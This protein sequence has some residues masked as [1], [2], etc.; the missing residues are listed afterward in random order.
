V[1]HVLIDTQA[2]IWFA[3]GSQALSKKARLAIDDS[4]ILQFASAASFW[5][6]AIKIPLGKLSLEAGTLREFT[7]LLTAN[8]IEVLGVTTDD[9][10]GVADLPIFDDHKDPFDRLIA[11]QCLRHNLT[12]V[13]KDASFDRYGVKPIW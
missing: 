6:M 3:N 11:A 10:V 5:E 7:I 9:A 4:S 13:S 12:I 8:E 1:S 2:L